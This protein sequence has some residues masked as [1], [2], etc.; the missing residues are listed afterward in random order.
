MIRIEDAPK[1]CIR[2]NSGL[3]INV[4][5]PKPF[6][7]SVEDIAHALSFQCRFAGHLN[8]FYSVAQHSVLCMRMAKVDKLGALLHDGSEA[9]ISDMPS[10]IKARMPEYKII[11]DVLMTAIA[12]KFGFKFPLSEEVKNIDRE[13]LLLEWYHLVANDNKN[14]ECWTPEKAKFEFLESYFKLKEEESIVFI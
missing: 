10:P 12:E 13:I 8:R 2:T 5:E 4:F 14:F 1:D 6:M 9:Y 11:E 3:F 7:I